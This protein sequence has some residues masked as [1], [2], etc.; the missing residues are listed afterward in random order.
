VRKRPNVALC[1]GI[2]IQMDLNVTGSSVKRY[3]RDGKR[4]KEQHVRLGADDAVCVFI[5]LDSPIT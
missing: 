3:A 1:G 2:S 4:L 5:K